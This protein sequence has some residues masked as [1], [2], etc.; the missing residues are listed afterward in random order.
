M[1]F[2]SLDPKEAEYRWVF[3][4]FPLW[5]PL[6]SA[7]RFIALGLWLFGCLFLLRI[8]SFIVGPFRTTRHNFRRT[9][10]H[11]FVS[12]FC[13]IIG[14][15]IRVEG[16]RPKRPYLVVMNHISWVDF[17]VVARI[18]G[19]CC[20]CA[21][22]DI[23]TFPLVGALIR[24]GGPVPVRRVREAV[25][26]TLALMERELQRGRA[27]MLAPEGVVGP[28][29]RVRRFRASLLEVAIRLN[30][31]V[32]YMSLTSRTPPGY[33]PASKII[34]KGPDHFFFGEDIPQEELDESGP[35]QHAI[36]HLLRLLSVPWHEYTVRFGEEAISGTERIPLAQSLQTAVESIFTPVE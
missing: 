27:M 20:I 36:P 13:M 9:V 16:E 26:E 7:L 5:G 2:W 4:G 35:P 11:I 14:T 17:F 8:G 1:L 28:G 29:K 31:P 24:A 21:Q 10:Y 33:P 32:H 22:D 12:G 34:F 3:L 6:R 30:M 18:L 15:R 19:E 23:T 25:P